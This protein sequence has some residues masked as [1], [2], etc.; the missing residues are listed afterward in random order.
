MDFIKKI[1]KIYDKCMD[2]TASILSLSVIIIVVA[3]SI[4]VFTRFLPIDSVL[5]TTDLSNCLLVALGF[6][7]AGWLLRENAHVSID[8]V[9]NYLGRTKKRIINIIMS[10]VGIITS[11][12]LVYV[13]SWV[14]YNNFVRATKIV[15]GEWVIPKFLLLALIPIGMTFMGIE[16]LRKLYINIKGA[17]PEENC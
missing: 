9:Y 11:L 6:L 10:V 5:W 15:T 12:A 8:L 13:G 2:W 4:Q 1:I 14:T 7:G 16:F 3:I 17:P